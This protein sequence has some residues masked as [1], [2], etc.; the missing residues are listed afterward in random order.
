[1]QLCNK[2]IFVFVQILC[3]CCIPSWCQPAAQHREPCVTHT[4]TKSCTTKTVL[5]FWKMLSSFQSV[6]SWVIFSWI[7]KS[8]RVRTVSGA[9][10]EI[11]SQ[12]GIFTVFRRGTTSA[13][14]VEVVHSHMTVHFFCQALYL[15]TFYLLII[16]YY[17]INLLGL[18]KPLEMHHLVAC[19]VHSLL[20]FLPLNMTAKSF[21]RQHVNTNL[22]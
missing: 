3:S 19:A 2:H 13:Q 18:H 17:N 5:Y 1:M 8:L 7:C 4:Q 9:D 11:T 10:V 16:I 14:L 21:S 12:W 15:S 20:P 22:L 6:E